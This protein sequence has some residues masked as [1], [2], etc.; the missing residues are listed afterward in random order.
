MDEEKNQ[1]HQTGV[2]KHRRTSKLKILNF[3]SWL[4]LKVDIKKLQN[5]DIKIRNYA[6][7][8]NFY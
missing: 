6:V 8:I 2:E 7:Y 1:H 4:H 5:V 3:N